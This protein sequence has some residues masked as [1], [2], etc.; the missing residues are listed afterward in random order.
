[1]NR[2]A[3]INAMGGVYQGL[4]RFVCREKLWADMEAEKMTIKVG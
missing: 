1:M 3:S 2:D 4:D